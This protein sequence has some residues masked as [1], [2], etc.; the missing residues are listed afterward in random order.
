MACRAFG[1]ALPQWYNCA[2]PQRLG[3][4][5]IMTVLT[6]NNL[7]RRFG[8]L[9]VFQGVNVRI[10]KGD[11]IGL[12]GPNGEGK[13]TLLRILAGIDAPSDGAVVR[14]RGLS[15]GYLPQDA[16]PP[17]DTLP[18]GRRGQPVCAAAPPG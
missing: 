10:E 5:A 4:S 12:V 1:V 11:R 13:T 17:G 3:G 14:A 8:P 15:I 2:G 7:S 6:G 9:D 16:P 18:L